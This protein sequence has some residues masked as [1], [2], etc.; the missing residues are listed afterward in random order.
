MEDE[1][2]TTEKTVNPYNIIIDIEKKSDEL[3][4]IFVEQRNTKVELFEID[5]QEDAEALC[6]IARMSIAGMFELFKTIREAKN[7]TFN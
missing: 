5:N 7:A 4:S 3:Y 6:N 2:N 1:V